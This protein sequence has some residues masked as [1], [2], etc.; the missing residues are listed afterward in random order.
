[1]PRVE[2]Q[3]QQRQ[4]SAGDHQN[5]RHVAPLRKIQRLRCAFIFHSYLFK[6]PRSS[7]GTSSIV[8]SR[9]NC[10]ARK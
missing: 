3:P 2:D 1:M 8:P 6:F 7:C 9:A 5:R 10:K 4:Q